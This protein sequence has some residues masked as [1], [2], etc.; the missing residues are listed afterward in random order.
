M[1]KRTE[2]TY[3]ELAKIDSERPVLTRAEAEQV[4]IQI[5]YEGYIKMQKV[6]V[7]NFK[8]LENKKLPQEIDYNTVNGISLEAKQK[9]N[10][11][12][13][14][15]VG[16][17]SRISGISPADIGVLLVFMEQRNGRLATKNAPNE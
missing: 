11:F 7:E 5:K 8:K 3:N 14:T 2:L 1:L 10:K 4:Q 17:A 13:P 12:K 6:Q 16:Q 15:S 9:L